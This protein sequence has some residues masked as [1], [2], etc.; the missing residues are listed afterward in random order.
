MVLDLA[1]NV[2]CC[3]MWIVVVMWMW[4]VVVLDLACNVQY[5][6]LIVALTG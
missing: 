6:F 2:D 5:L 1:C 4:I 3:V